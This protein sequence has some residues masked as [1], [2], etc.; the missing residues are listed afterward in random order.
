MEEK[1]PEVKRDVRFDERRKEL[2][3]HNTEERDLKSGETVLGSV[4]LENRAIYNEEGIRRLYKNAQQDR[5]VAEQTI[6]RC[7]ELAGK[8]PTE[9]EL[10]ELEEHNKTQ[11]RLQ[12]IG[13]FEENKRNLKMHEEKLKDV[14]GAINEIKSAIGTRLKL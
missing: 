5:T 7:K 12:E 14:N 4:I 3:I 9:E 13:K 11:M 1:K 2:H 8:E 10:K 6:K